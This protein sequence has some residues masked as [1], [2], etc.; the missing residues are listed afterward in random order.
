MK[1]FHHLKCDSN[2]NEM[3][4]SYLPCW[5]CWGTDLTLFNLSLLWLG[6]LSL[7]VILLHPGSERGSD[8]LLPVTPWT[9]RQVRQSYRWT[10]HL[11]AVFTLVICLS[12]SS[13]VKSMR[14]EIDTWRSPLL[15]P[16]CLPPPHHTQPSCWLLRRPGEDKTECVC[17]CFPY[18]NRR[19]SSVTDCSSHALIG[20]E[21]TPRQNN[22][23]LRLHLT[24][25]H[26][27]GRRWRLESNQQPTLPSQTLNLLHHFSQDI[28]SRR[29]SRLIKINPSWCDLTASDSPRLSLYCRNF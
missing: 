7:V 9:H 29:S 18:F 27:G 19:S 24:L 28:Y 8:F 20:S 1:V 14:W 17:C 13:G 26:H 25:Y 11:S 4:E 16:D 10:R 2:S 22:S 23:S 3:I 15:L 21:P 5:S 6:D 12:L